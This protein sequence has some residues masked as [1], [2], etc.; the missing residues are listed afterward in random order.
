MRSGLCASDLMETAMDNT[1]TRRMHPLTA[2]AAVSV[3]LFSLVGI[4][5]I[6]GLIPTSHSQSTPTPVAK[7]AE[8]PL[9]ST[10][11]APPAES[12]NMGTAAAPVPA[13]RL[14]VHKAVV[15]HAK[16]AA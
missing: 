15:K 10:A 14:P 6:T 12:A 1:T 11:V 16:P 5:A 2:I 3:T 13:D 7:P 4:G 8:E 9:K